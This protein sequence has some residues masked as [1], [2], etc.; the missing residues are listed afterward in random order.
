MVGAN[1]EKQTHSLTS[2]MHSLHTFWPH[3]MSS[4]ELPLFY[5]NSLRYLF[6]VSREK[7]SMAARSGRHDDEVVSEGMQP[8]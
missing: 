1:K 2:S 8:S 6:E 4:F 7:Y 3:V 5:L